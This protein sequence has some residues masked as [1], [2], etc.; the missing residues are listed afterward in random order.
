MHLIDGG[1][2]T[3]LERLGAQ[4]TGELWTGR[5]LLTQPDLVAAAHKNFVAAGAEVIISSSYQL[6]R[7]G[8]IEIGLDQLDADSALVSSIEIAR[9]ATQGTSCQVAA[10][11]GPYGAV[12]HDGSEYQGDYKVSQAQLEDFHFE[13][14][15]ILLSA[16]PDLLAVETI[17]NV[18]EA[19]ALANVLSKVSIPCWVSFTSATQ[20]KLWSGEYLEDAALAV[21]GLENL[22][23]VGLNCV[24]PEIVRDGIIRINKVTGI[25]GV[26][27]P[28]CGGVWDA[29]KDS[30]VGA[31]RKSLVEWLPSWQDCP[32]AYLGGCCGTDS[33]EIANLHQALEKQ[34]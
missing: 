20:E 32:I 22:I 25:L 5:T 13:R 26:A 14:L 16:K 7:K 8:F 4:I 18:L 3:E 24:D 21:A 11:V 19:K 23:A 6:S 31:S 17:P 1:L 30:W 27:Y 33:I 9:S 15:E 29:A 28:N 2:S 34:N 12:L 10:S